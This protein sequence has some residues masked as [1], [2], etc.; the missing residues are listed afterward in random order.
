MFLVNVVLSGVGPHLFTVSEFYRV[1]N[2]TTNY[3][4]VVL[5]V[6]IIIKLLEQVT[7]TDRIY[8]KKIKVNYIYKNNVCNVFFRH[9]LTCILSL[10]YCL[11]I[12][13]NS[14]SVI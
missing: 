13:L 14:I 7:F 12:F 8:I 3:P 5:Q 10:D 9:L 2:K 11:V 4:L 1:Y 6:F